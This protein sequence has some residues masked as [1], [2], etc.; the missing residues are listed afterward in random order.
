MTDKCGWIIHILRLQEK[1]KFRKISFSS[2]EVYG[3]YA[4]ETTEAMDMIN[5]SLVKINA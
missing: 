2:T 3:G 1:L 5:N 4:G